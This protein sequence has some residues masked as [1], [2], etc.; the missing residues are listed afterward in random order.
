MRNTFLSLILVAFW[1]VGATAEEPVIDYSAVAK[2]ISTTMA[3]HH[4]NPAE[5]VTPEYAAIEKAVCNLAQTAK[6]DEAFVDGFQEIW[7]DG[8]FSHVNLSKAQG[9]AED[10]AAFFDAMNVGENGATL[11]W[12]GDTAILT[13]NTMMGVDTI[14]RIEAAYDEIHEKGAQK[15]II[16]LR[17]NEGGAFAVR[18]LA[19]HLT[20]DAFIAGG[21]VSQPWNRAYD[22]KPTL[23]DMKSVDP[24]SG[25]SIRAF[26]ADAQSNPLTVAQFE[27]MAPLFDGPVFVLTSK[28]TASAAELVT[29]AL[30]ASGRAKVIG[31][32]TAGQMLSQ[33]VYDIVGGFHLNVPIADYYSAANGR[34]EGV[35][36]AP[37]IKI[38]A[39]K[40]MDIALEL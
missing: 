2:S 33:K 28:R 20:R 5:L 8:P 16:D 19:G 18:P 9:A 27:P 34:I 31:E 14:A 7:R 15:L 13:V 11:A 35:G 26:W 40:A 24:W 29:D 10:L 3:A 23:E 37:D 39:S 38:Q 30:Q 21:F 12:K 25:W 22:R 4:Y 36:V 32:R 1:C 17:R 6:T